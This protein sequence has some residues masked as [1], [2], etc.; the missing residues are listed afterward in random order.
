MINCIFV[1]HG[2]GIVRMIAIHGEKSVHWL[3]PKKVR[4]KQNAMSGIFLTNPLASVLNISC[5]VFSYLSSCDQNFYEYANFH[6]SV[7]TRSFDMF[8]VLTRSKEAL[9]YFN[10]IIDMFSGVERSR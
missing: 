7:F 2:N 4:Y 5:K 9:S 1:R 6:V 8:E 3:E 10:L